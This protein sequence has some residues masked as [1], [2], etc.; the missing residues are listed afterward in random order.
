MKP[1]LAHKA[2][3]AY[4]LKK[5]DAWLDHPWGHDAIKIGKKMFAILGDDEGFGFTAKLPDSH[6]AAITMFGWAAPTEYGMGKSGW[7][8][9]RFGKKDDVPVELLKQWIDESYEAI[10]P[11][12][13]AAKTAKAPAKKRAARAR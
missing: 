12:P 7:V 5:K 4:A 10:A 11:K 6:E 13:R 9:A 3:K 8:T 1:A 2:L